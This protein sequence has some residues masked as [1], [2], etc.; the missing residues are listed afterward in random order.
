MADVDM[1]GSAA[2]CSSPQN[3]GFG[4][5]GTGDLGDL[6]SEPMKAEIRSFDSPD[7][8]HL[9]TWNP[10]T[11]GW[12]ILLRLM[13]GPI[14][15]RGEESFDVTVC[16]VERI[17]QQVRTDGVVDGRHTLVVENFDWQNL[18]SFLHRRVGSLGADTWPELATK[19]SRLGFWEFEDYRP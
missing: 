16:D 4:A 19:L 9:S 14:G 17:S 13:I 12:S 11:A 7:V 5:D 15:G 10:E 8:E 2:C 1:R 6:R 3:A 18:S